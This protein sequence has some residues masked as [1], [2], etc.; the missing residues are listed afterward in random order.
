MSRG[1]ASKPRA[2]RR[3]A[4]ALV[5]FSG[6][7]RLAVAGDFLVVEHTTNV[8]GAPARPGLE[9]KMT[10]TRMNPDFATE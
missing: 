8:V 7:G 4:R 5:T 10:L 2:G 9:V 6:D 3:S 1:V